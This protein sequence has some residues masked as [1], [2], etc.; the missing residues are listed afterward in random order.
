MARAKGSFLYRSV[1][2]LLLGPLLT[3]A[4]G[5]GL[6]G[7]LDVG[8]PLDRPP[9]I[10][11]FGRPVTHF[12]ERV[13]HRPP[14]RAA[15]RRVIADIGNARASSAFGLRTGA[16]V[17]DPLLAQGQ[18]IGQAP[19]PA[20]ETVFRRITVLDATH[21]RVVR[22]NAPLTIQFAGVDGPAF[23]AICTDGAGARWKC[24]ARGRAEVAR[25][26]RSRS[27]GCSDIVDTGDGTAAADCYVG[28]TSLSDWVVAEGWA[29]PIDPYDQRFRPLAD[30]A[31]QARK[32]RLL[33]APRALP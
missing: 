6:S 32:G 23:D 22:D 1:A 30:A 29:D 16:A 15:D 21:F 26:I 17:T 31:R 25:L 33:D 3:A 2:P 7:W 9:W 8:T 5:Y 10:T 20:F 28:P 13:P 18:E 19:P 24:G 11:D 14:A 27:V 4:L 12:A